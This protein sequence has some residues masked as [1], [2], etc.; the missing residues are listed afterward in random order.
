MNFLIDEAPA[1]VDEKCGVT[2]CGELQRAPSSLWVNPLIWLP[3][4]QRALHKLFTVFRSSCGALDLP[5]QRTQKRLWYIYITHT[6]LSYCGDWELNGWIGDFSGGERASKERR[7]FTACQCGVQHPCVVV[8]L[9][10]MGMGSRRGPHWTTNQ[11][12]I[13]GVLNITE[14]LVY[15]LL[16]S[17]LTHHLFHSWYILLS[18]FL[19]V[20]SEW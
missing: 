3:K 16:N 20:D 10:K 17:P 7:L 18:F 2:I 19:L 6:L 5:H 1:R 8:P 12:T 11:W 15:I 9:T 4:A 13:C 14:K